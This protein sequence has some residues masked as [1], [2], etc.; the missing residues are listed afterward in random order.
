MLAMALDEQLELFPKATRQDIEKAKAMLS[1]YRR[2]KMI[3]DDFER[4]PPE[5]V[6]QIEAQES[7]T[8]YTR[9]IE[10]AV[11]QIVDYDVKSVIE[12]RFLRGN[13]RAATILRFSGWDYCDKTI[14]RKILDGIESVANSLLYL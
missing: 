9:I 3:L 4:N 10:R 6:K 1:R 2:M 5:T 7:T 14:D 8:R 13:S 12:Y 11:N